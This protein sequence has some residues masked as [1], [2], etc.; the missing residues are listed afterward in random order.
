[1]RLRWNRL[2]GRLVLAFLLIVAVNLSAI[3]VI[4]VFQQRLDRFAA[5]REKDLE[6]E[7]RIEA[8]LDAI[9]ELS[10]G[11][12]MVAAGQS[13]VGRALV[14]ESEGRLATLD[15]ELAAISW[16]DSVIEPSKLGPCLDIRRAL[17]EEARR[18]LSL[19]GALETQQRVLS[20][21]QRVEMT[22]ALDIALDQAAILAEHAD[23][24][25]VELVD[26]LH[27]HAQRALAENARL[28]RWTSTLTLAAASV[29]L[30]FAL[31][32]ALVFARSL[33]ARLAALSRVV[34]AFGRGELTQRAHDRGRDEIGDLA[35]TFDHMADAIQAQ[36][37]L[38][39]S[40][41]YVDDI[42]DTMTNALVVLDDQA[43]IEKVNRATCQL[44][45]CEEGELVGAK[46]ERIF[47]L[48]SE[49]THAA[50]PVPW[51]SDMVQNAELALTTKDGDTRTVAFS[52]ATMTDR[53]GTK[54]VCLLDDIT[55]RK[56]LIF[57]LVEAKRTAESATKAKTTFLANMSHE[58]RTPLNAILGYAQMLV[59]DGNLTE[60]QRDAVTTMRTSGEHL[61]RLLEDLLDIS[62]IEADRMELQPSEFRLSRFLDDLVALFRMRAQQKGLLF[63]YEVLSELP[64]VRADERRLRQV[65]IN[66]LGNAIK[67]TERGRVT[68]KVH[69]HQGRMRFEV[70]DTGIGIPPEVHEDIF[71]PFRQGGPPQRRVEGTGLGLAISKRL[72]ELMG[73]EIGVRSA[74]G[75]GSTF[76]VDL[77]LPA[78]SSWREA[79]SG[80]NGPILGYEG[81]RRRILLVDDEAANRTMLA[82]YLV[83]LGFDIDEAANGKEALERVDARVPD[84]VLMDVRMPV[85]DGLAATR[86]LRKRTAGQD[87]VI[88]A[89]SASAF[90]D[91]REDCLRAGCDGFLAKPM[92]L[93]ALL[94]QLGALLDLQWV[95][96]EPPDDEPSD[97]DT[98]IWELPPISDVAAL[99]E[100]AQQGDIKA[101]R[102]VIDRV[103]GHAAAYAPFCEELRTWAKQYRLKQIRMHLEELLATMRLA[104]PEAG[105]GPA[106]APEASAKASPETSPAASGGE[107]GAGSAREP[108]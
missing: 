12:F 104:S 40:K 86:A 34:D 65:L 44:L 63:H 22:Q 72:V 83:P 53:L 9:Q 108:G 6:I 75:Q 39:M 77:A 62:K 84:V 56:E 87:I 67:F 80:V 7:S 68:L 52:S 27:D 73:G 16:Q 46:A 36:D 85:M 30:G 31:V 66:L 38:R 91:D 37:G 69:V 32:I 101:L 59:D 79:E 15:D 99:L 105:A 71:A 107:G 57:Q 82:Q 25:V 55:E 92:H 42:L 8:Y 106:P 58:L 18:I 23:L 11:L 19:V 28:T 61:A 90:D 20:E 103:E 60:Q 74:L 64:A 43:V 21:A 95:R 88:L 81:P 1:M 50:A 33:V 14:L 51:Q 47:G 93:D 48:F 26:E 29:S 100:A 76:W 35:R 41:Q 5:H 96:A 4:R 24:Y 98:E 45:G 89:I 54:I 102:D 13:D 10:R 2:G 97:V 70:E 94:A 17:G 49:A 3:A 78:V